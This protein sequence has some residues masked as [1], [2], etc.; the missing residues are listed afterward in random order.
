MISKKSRKVIAAVLIGATV[1]ASGTFAYFNKTLDFSGDNVYKGKA[2]IAITNG[3]IDITGQI[4]STALTDYTWSYDVARLSTD[5]DLADN[6]GRLS[7]TAKTAITNSLKSTI[8]TTNFTSTAFKAGYNKS[9]TEMQSTKN[10]A[11]SSKNYVYSNLSPDITGFDTNNVVYTTK[12]ADGNITVSNSEVTGYVKRTNV[13][14]KLTG[15]I[16]NARPGDAIVLGNASDL[17]QQGLVINNKSNLTTNIRIRV[18]NDPEALKE[19]KLL[20]KAGWVLYINNVNITK[21]LGDTDPTIDSI[22]AQIEKIYTSVPANTDVS[23]WKAA[24]TVENNLKNRFTVRL[25]LPLAT[26]NTYQESKTEDGGKT[27]FDIRNIFEVVATQ[28]N[29]P[30]WNEDGGDSNPVTETSTVNNY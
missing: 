1:C 26:T 15:A 19:F 30:G 12:A 24:E 18:K 16:A 7:D 29:N 14:A 9:N 27:F 13:G 5:E 3:K 10:D 2:E 4:G 21:M 28:E 23:E 11:D 22:N 8:N 25:E 6:T 17:E 20:K